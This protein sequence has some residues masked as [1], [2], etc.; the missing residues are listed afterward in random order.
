MQPNLKTKVRR[1]KLGKLEDRMEIAGQILQLLVE[2]ADFQGKEIEK[3]KSWVR[4][5]SSGDDPLASERLSEPSQ[6]QS[7]PSPEDSANPP[8]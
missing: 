8:S 4:S 1:S 7:T 6:S 5:T 2:R 3:I